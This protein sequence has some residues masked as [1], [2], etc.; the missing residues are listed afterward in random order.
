[1]AAAVVTV[2]VW[3]CDPP[4]HVTEHG[5]KA[6]QLDTTQLTGHGLLLHVATSVV[7]GQLAPPNCPGV[8]MVRDRDCDPPPHVVLQLSHVPQLDTTQSTGQFWVLQAAVSLRAP[9]SVPPFWAG[10]TTVR[11]RLWMP[12]PQDAEQEPKALQLVSTQL[13]GQPCVLHDPW[14][15][16]KIWLVE[17]RR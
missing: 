3:L 12:L 4:P 16:N 15:D 17:V 1:L 5:P 14:G 9:H 8:M 2:R 6:P 10:V 7:A 11:L 13:T